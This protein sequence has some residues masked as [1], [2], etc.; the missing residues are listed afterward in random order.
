MPVWREGAVTLAQRS[1]ST[2]INVCQDRLPLSPTCL[3]NLVLTNL[4]TDRCEMK[5]CMSPKGW[6]QDN[7]TREDYCFNRM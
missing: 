1:S 5:P 3:Q 2:V 4:L 6:K 7:K